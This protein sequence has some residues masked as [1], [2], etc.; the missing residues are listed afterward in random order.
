LPESVVFSAN[1]E[2]ESTITYR[3][4]ENDVGIRSKYSGYLPLTEKKFSVLVEKN[5]RFLRTEYYYESIYSS[6]YFGSKK[7]HFYVKG[8]LVKKFDLDLGLMIHGLEIENI[9]VNSTDKSIVPNISRNDFNESQ[10]LAI[11]YSIKKAII[12]NEIR[13]SDPIER[14]I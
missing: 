2:I 10:S 1:L 12:L 11:S 8:V 9:V 5:Q 4:I 13:N 6:Y 14:S 7:N 3:D